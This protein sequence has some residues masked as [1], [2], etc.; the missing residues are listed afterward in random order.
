MTT[1]ECDRFI[2]TVLKVTR[3]LWRPFCAIAFLHIAILKTSRDALWR[4]FCAIA[5]SV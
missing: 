2:L 1:I 3:C 5:I 4:P